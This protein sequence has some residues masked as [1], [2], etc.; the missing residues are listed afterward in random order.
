MPNAIRWSLRGISQRRRR[1]AATAQRAGGAGGAT[2]RHGRA[3]AARP[4]PAHRRVILLL[5]EMVPLPQ[6]VEAPEAEQ[7]EVVAEAAD[8]AGV[9]RLPNLRYPKPL[10]LR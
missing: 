5:Q 3:A 4:Q 2:G 8:V 10:K 6:G 7:A 9:V 1:P